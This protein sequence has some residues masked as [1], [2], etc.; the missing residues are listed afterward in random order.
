MK[1]LQDRIVMQKL[2]KEGLTLFASGFSK[3]AEAIEDQLQSD[4]QQQMDNRLAMCSRLHSTD[5][6]KVPL[7]MISK[8]WVEDVP[9]P[10]PNITLEDI[11]TIPEDKWKKISLLS[12]KWDRY[13]L[14]SWREEVESKE[15]E[16]ELSSNIKSEES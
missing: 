1:T 5:W 16:E 2:L 15:F 9:F 8:I 11:A 12:E 4:L 13:F 3:I 14:N 10:F 7:G 6:S